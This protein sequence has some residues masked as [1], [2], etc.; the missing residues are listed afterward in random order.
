MGRA[1][2]TSKGSPKLREEVQAVSGGNNPPGGGGGNNPPGG[3]SCTLQVNADGNAAV[4]MKLNGGSPQEGLGTHTLPK[5]TLVHLQGR[6]STRNQDVWV[7]WQGMP[8]RSMG[9]KVV[10]RIQKD[11]SLTAVVQ[12]KSNIPKDN[13]LHHGGTWIRRPGVGNDRA[14]SKSEALV[15]QLLQE[16]GLGADEAQ[17]LA[18][19]L[20]AD[21]FSDDAYQ[22][23]LRD[24]PGID[25]DTLG[26]LHPAIADKIPVS[27]P[28][29][30]LQWLRGDHS[31][32]IDPETSAP[33]M[34]AAGEMLAGAI[35]DGERVAIFVD[36]D[37]DGV[38][39]GEVLRLALEAHDADF[40]IGY[41][42]MQNGFGLN[43]DF[44]RQ[45]HADGCRVLV[46]AD[47]GSESVD[48][49][50][51]AQELGMRVIVSDHHRIESGYDN[52]A[53]FHLNPQLHDTPATG[54]TGSQMA[55]KLAQS[56]HE[57][58]GT[59]PSAHYGEAMWWAG[60]GCRADGGEM[61]DTSNRPFL[62]SRDMPPG[63]REIAELVGENPD[64]DMSDLDA[65]RE[66]INLGKR[67][68]HIENVDMTEDLTKDG[69]QR[70]EDRFN[71]ETGQY[72][73]HGVRMKPSSDQVVSR[74]DFSPEDVARALSDPDPK[75]RKQA[76]E[77]LMR[78]YQYYKRL[79]KE[80][81][82][83]VKSQ[84]PQSA[85]EADD[86]S[87][88]RPEEQPLVN[89]VVLEDERMAGLSRKASSQVARRTRT[90]GIAFVPA[91]VDEEG[92]ELVR[93][94]GTAVDGQGAPM[95]DM[96]EVLRPHSVAVG[97]HEKVFGGTCRK[98]DIDDLMEAANEWAAKQK[99]LL[100]RSIQ[101]PSGDTFVSAERVSP[102]ELSR[103]EKG[104]RALAP[105]TESYNEKKLF[106]P[107][108]S[109][110]GT[111]EDIVDPPAETD[112]RAGSSG[113]TRYARIRL[114]DGSQ[115]LVKFAG[116][117]DDRAKLDRALELQKG[118]PLEFALKIYPTEGAAHSVAGW[119][120][121]AEAVPF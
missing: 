106:G 4:T 97:G 64:S 80:S 44:V 2:R 62:V 3:S 110:M 107:T 118:E 69:K 11:E 21:G 6:V 78:A 20:R 74:E 102:A 17:S 19:G 25:A 111:L 27:D 116:S 99:D 30:A 46:T 120:P 71:F 61:L 38:S 51:L 119:R 115:R 50:K 49:V 72:E 66:I 91:G 45:A 95:G 73:E 32:I 35:A 113:Y 92:N 10:F 43:E 47:C 76:Q 75:E 12:S 83:A 81:A 39:S 29:E 16:S 94:S 88:V 68:D 58:T 13:P 96:I 101:G 103:L 54:E 26:A 9:R 1:R 79:E 93:F 86:G 112:K 70:M 59:I 109:V 37:A 15:A 33:G 85:E 14:E 7:G 90:P 48:A 52:P 28:Q 89:H 108:V 77:K 18:A 42:D 100:P 114:E 56:L 65:T 98:E 22:Q 31:A 105:F 53:D 82:S 60:F 117:K 87:I 84:F 104:E 57:A 55:W 8:S 63:V 23:L 5:G 121:A 40:Q 24:V 41:A 67:L 34:R 36:Y